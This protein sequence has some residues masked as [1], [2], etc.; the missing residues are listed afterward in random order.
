MTAS[1]N[2]PRIIQSEVSVPLPNP[3]LD[4]TGAES[5]VP[6][7][8]V[9]KIL[10]CQLAKQLGEGDRVDRSNLQEKIACV[11]EW[12]LSLP[13]V[14]SII[15]P[16]KR[17][18][19][20]CPHIPFQRLQLHCIGYM[21]QV[22]FVRSVLLSSQLFSATN[23]VGTGLDSE[24]T[25]LMNQVV[26]LSLKAMAVSRDTFDL[27]FPQQAKYYMVAFCPFDNAALLCSLLIHDVPGTTIP[28]RSE[29]IYAIGQALYISHRLRGFTKVGDITWSLLS[30]LKNRI[31][32]FPLE[33]AILEELESAGKS[34]TT[35]ESLSHSLEPID[36]YFSSI[37]GS[38]NRLHSESDEGLRFVE[39]TL[40]ADDPELL[41]MDLGILDGVWNWER[42]GF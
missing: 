23:H 30:A 31:N 24:T 20:D 9:A 27:C 34:D 33:K 17:W 29:I 14:F 10:E 4:Q 15:D 28:R 19:G 36:E 7:Y 26:G 5:L 3:G 13:P 21:T 22:V 12:M 42:V 39:N 32:L 8:I 6:S 1:F 25:M 38:S 41:E 35:T 18:D 2:R 37:N 16:D 11:E 40:A